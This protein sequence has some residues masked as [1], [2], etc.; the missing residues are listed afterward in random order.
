MGIRLIGDG[1]HFL[2][3]GSVIDSTM[4]DQA[5]INLKINWGLVL[6]QKLPLKNKNVIKLCLTNR[7]IQNYSI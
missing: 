3:I 5:C 2:P 7:I 6:I 1:S 4:I